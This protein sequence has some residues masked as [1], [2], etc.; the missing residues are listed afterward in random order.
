MLILLACASNSRVLARRT[1]PR[2]AYAPTF[3]RKSTKRLLSR[4]DA[5]SKE[6][7]TTEK[8]I[9]PPW[10]DPRVL[11][12]QL[13]RKKSNYRRFRQHV[14][15]LAHQYQQPTLLTEEWPSNVFDD[16]QKPLHL[17]IGCG[18]GGFLLELAAH[19]K[20]RF[21]YLGLEIRPLVV[22][23]AKQRIVIHN[24]TGTLDFVGCNANVDLERIIQR[25][26]Q[27]SGSDKLNL[28]RVT[29]Q[30]HHGHCPR[31]LL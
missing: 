27:A 5:S 12:K 1:L 10:N 9:I 7:Q 21:N 22:Q 17:D 25:C 14:N 11:E 16:C 13:K 20:A 24:L 26:Q 19:E 18:K 8:E 30:V 28:E 15:P 3:H 31:C 4:H 2:I 23:Y 29:I 6:I